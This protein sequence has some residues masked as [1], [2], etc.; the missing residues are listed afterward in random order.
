MYTAISANP[1]CISRLSILIGYHTVHT[2]NYSSSVEQRRIPNCTRKLWISLSLS[3]F[4][5]K[6]RQQLPATQDSSGWSLCQLLLPAYGQ[7]YSWGRLCPRTPV[8]SLQLPAGSTSAQEEK[9]NFLACIPASKEIPDFLY[10]SGTGW[11]RIGQHFL[12][13]HEI[14]SYIYH[15]VAFMYRKFEIS[16][17]KIA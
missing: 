4:V 8:S 2:Q 16:Q 11:Y 13:L 15:P 5:W 3:R 12:T 9:L 7:Q 6:W 17:M 10:I 14:V 1:Y